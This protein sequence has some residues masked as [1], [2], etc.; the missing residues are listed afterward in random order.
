MTGITGDPFFFVH[1]MKTGGTTIRAHVNN[2]FAPHERYPEGSIDEDLVPAK[3]SV[4]RLLALPPQRH[5]QIRIY[6]GHFPFFAA[7]LLE[8]PLRVLTML[9]EPVERAISHLKQE[10]REGPPGRSLEEVY[11]DPWVNPRVIGNHQV[12]MFA[13]QAEDDVEAFYDK[14]LAVDEERLRTACDNL[15]RVEIVGFQDRHSAFI[16]TLV[17]RCGWKRAS[18]K[19]LR[20]SEPADVSKA[21]RR[22]ITEDNAAD[23]ALYEHARRTR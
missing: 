20:V 5:A 11:E 22:R 19:A 13:L 7:D 21:L 18:V 15:D 16:D 1:V 8:R 17:E 9:R 10:Q 2:T 6:T 14:T 12:R 4:H 3:L 23:I